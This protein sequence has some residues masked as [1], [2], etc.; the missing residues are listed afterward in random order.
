MFAQ[1]VWDTLSQIDISDHTDILEATEKR[2]A[3]RYLPWH[4]AWMLLRR[5]G[6]SL[7]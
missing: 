4:K 3:L 7:I 1:K 2:R 5:E 6:L